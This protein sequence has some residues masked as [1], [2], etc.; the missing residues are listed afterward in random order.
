MISYTTY[1]KTNVNKW[2]TLVHG[3]GGS[4]AIWYRQVKPFNEHFNVLIVDL[5]GHGNS[6]KG[7][8]ASK[9]S[10]NE[11]AKDITEVLDKLNIQQSH[12]IGISLGSII[13]RTLAEIY[14]NRV[15][16]IIMAGAIMKLNIRSQILM[17]LGNTFKTIIPFLLLYKFF[18]YIIMPRRNHKKSRLLFINEAKKLDQQEFIRWFKLTSEINGLLKKYRKTTSTI[19]F[20]YIMGSQDAMFLPSVKKLVTKQAANSTLIITPNSGHVVNIDQPNYFNKN[21]IEYLL[22]SS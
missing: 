2:V 21:C 9:Y 7:T 4:S 11:I 8:K 3:A 1:L 19:P 18:A 6:G 12:F 10:F 5:R 14:P 17:W 15:F 16:S 20:L 22:Q 13:I